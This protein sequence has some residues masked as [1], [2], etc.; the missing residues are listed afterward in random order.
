[1][2]Q[3][4]VCFVFLGWS[5]RPAAAYYFPFGNGY[6]WNNLGG[7]GNMA[8]SIPMMFGGGYY[9]SGMRNMFYSPAGYLPY[10]GQRLFQ[11][12][13]QQQYGNGNGAN[14]N[15]GSNGNGPNGNGN[16]SVGNYGSNGNGPN[17]N[18]NGSVGNYGSNGNGP[19]GNGPNG[20]TA[21]PTYQNNYTDP[22]PL[23]VPRQRTRQKR[24]GKGAQDQ[25]S[26]ARWNPTSA[27]GANQSGMPPMPP[28]RQ[29]IGPNGAMAAPPPIV[30]GTAGGPSPFA[31]GFVDTVNSKFGGDISKALFD[32]GTRG[33]AKAL[34]MTRDDGIFDADLSESRVDVVRK[35]FSDQSLDPQSKINAAKILL[36][37]STKN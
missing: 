26:Y 12:S 14:G 5:V 8:Y 20:N 9:S 33:W 34:G 1:M 7:L 32:P 27:Q 3:T 2:V 29:G 13:T 21:S 30:N 23:N 36:N 35:I 25:I 4:L 10:G 18:G 22:E 17:G 37:N 24:A 6:G 11:P 15:Y 16:G 19:S 31:S 28:S